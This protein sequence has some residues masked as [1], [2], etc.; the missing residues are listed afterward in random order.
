MKLLTLLTALAIA[1]IALAHPDH[2][3]TPDHPEH[4]GDHPEHPSDDK[5]DAQASNESAEQA[6]ALLR[7]VHDT[8]K[9][10]T[11]ITETILLTMP[12]EE[13]EETMTVNIFLNK[14]SGKIVAED[15]MT[16]AWTNGTFYLSLA[17]KEDSYVEVEADSFGSGLEKATG[18]NGMPGLWTISIRENETLEEWL[19]TFSMGMPGTEIVGVSAQTQDDGIAVE[20][21]ELKTMMGSINIAV[22]SE[23]KIANVT[24]VFEQPGMPPMELSAVAKIAFVDTIPAVTFDAGD[25]KKFAS[26]DEMFGDS[27]PTGGDDSGLDGKVAPDFTL[28]TLDG[29]GEVTLSS[30]KGSVVVLDFWATWCPPCKKGLPFLNEF[31]AWTQEEGLNVKVFAVDVWERGEADAILEKVTKFWSDNKYTTTVLMAS[32]SDSLT[33]DYSVSGIPTTVI[34]GTD[35]KVIETHVGFSPDMVDV[36]KK[37]VTSAL[38]TSKPDHP[39]HPGDHPE[40][41][42][43]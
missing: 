10:A 20:V 17:E 35:G 7:K 6:E 38:G 1:P 32:G 23:N 24:M 5:G 18:G 11:A 43:G 2:D 34:I 39:E 36:L 26:L 8:Y 13:E 12:G 19:D 33:K 4:P 30:L 16:A 22:T 21:I 37:A 15:S 42:G 40:H 25:R 31:D 29:S 9:N 3:P 14:E 28:A 27:A 41:P